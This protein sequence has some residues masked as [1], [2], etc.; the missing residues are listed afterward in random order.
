MEIAWNRV[1]NL[2][3]WVLQG[4]LSLTFIFFGANKLDPHATSWV[5]MFSRIGI[6]QW[7]RYFTGGLEVVFA[8]LLLI[9][10]TAAAAA[11]VLAC[12]MG[13]AV[14]THL[15][16]LR[17]GYAVVFPALPLILLIVVAWSRRLKSERD[18]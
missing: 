18:G 15:F 11:T 2:L 4:V 10:R 16:I 7:F 1:C 9:P 13:G 6:G 17:D 14:L 12:I 5:E 3:L 8:V